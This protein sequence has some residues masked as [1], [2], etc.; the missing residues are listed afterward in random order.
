MF[1]HI[2]KMLVGCNIDYDAL[3]SSQIDVHFFDTYDN[4]R[5]VNSFLF[6]F[7]KLQDKIGAKLFKQVLYELKEIDTFE[8]P[9]LDILHMLEKMKIIDSVLQWEKLREIRNILAHEYPFET[10]ERLENITLA[11]EGFVMLKEVYEALKKS[12]L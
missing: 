2:D 7:G 12:V 1:E 11:M 8:Q 9:M 4:T 5:I 10:E 6:N 3:S